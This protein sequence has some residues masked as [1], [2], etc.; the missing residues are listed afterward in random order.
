MPER[1]M[2]IEPSS[3]GGLLLRF[4]NALLTRRTVVYCCSGA[5]IFVSVTPSGAIDE[6]SPSRFGTRLLNCFNLE[7]RHLYI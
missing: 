2:L 7:N 3:G 5:H 4:R 6:I 1:Q